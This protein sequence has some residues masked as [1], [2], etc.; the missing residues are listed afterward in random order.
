MLTSTDN[1][2][3]Y[4]KNFLV[5]NP[6]ASLLIVHGLGEHCERYAHVA[7][8]FNAIDVNVYT[9]DLR[10][11]GQSEG[12]RAYVKDINSY[13]EDVETVYQ[14]VPKDLPLFILGHSMGGLI[15]LTFLMHTKRADIKGAI[16]SGSALEIGEDITPVTQK[17]ITFL[18]KIA[19][20]LKTIKLDPKSIS[21][22][23]ETVEKYQTDPLIYH[24]GVKAGMG[25]AMLNGINAIKPKFS[26]FDYPALIMH[27]GSDKITNIAGSKAF[28]EQSKSK[29]K[30]LKIW[31]GDY[32]EIFNETNRT[33]VIAHTVAWLKER[34]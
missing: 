12:E 10:G 4:T 24:E 6:K 20:K 23:P 2:K 19:P 1:L 26:A 27:G 3:L 5:A 14:T 17:V 21:T 8:A 16:F 15:I 33:E 28:Y 25:V 31:E 30:S 9:F 22:D 11:H 13:R 34:I 18:A 7:Q 32:H 29:D